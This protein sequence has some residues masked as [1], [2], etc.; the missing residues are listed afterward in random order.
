MNFPNKHRCGPIVPGKGIFF[1]ALLFLWHGLSFPVAERSRSAGLPS[2]I[3]SG[4]ISIEVEGFGVASF[5]YKDFAPLALLMSRLLSPFSGFL[6]PV[7]CLR[8]PLSCYLIP[9]S[10]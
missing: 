6:S 3:N 1:D 9:F 8:S 7:S 5:F 4:G 2:P 10:E